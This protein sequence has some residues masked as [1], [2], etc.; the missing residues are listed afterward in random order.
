MRGDAA[1]GGDMRRLGENDPR[2][3]GRAGAE[4][5]H[6]P[7]VPQAVIGAVLAHRV[8]TMRLRAVTERKLIGWN[9][10]GVDM[11][12]GYPDWTMRCREPIASRTCEHS[13]VMG[14]AEHSV[15][16]VLGRPTAMSATPARCSRCS[17]WAPRCGRSTPC[18]SPTTPATG[19][20]PARSTPAQS[21]RDLVDGIA[22]RDASPA[23]AMRCCPAMWA[24]R[25]SATPSCTR[26]TASGGP[27]RRP[28]IAAIRSSATP[29]RGVYVRPGIEDFLRDRALPAADIVTPNRFEL[30]R[31]T[32]LDCGTLHGAKQAVLR[33]RPLLR[34]GRPGLRAADQPGDGRD[35]GRI[36]RHDD[37]S[38]RGAFI[39]C[40]RRCCRS[41]STA[42]AMRSRRC[43]CSTG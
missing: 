11:R 8:T 9:S 15:D 33:L 30:E 43:S 23:T 6:V 28:C 22:A 4:V 13:P 27:T 21:V 41:R 32:G 26:S 19:I 24:A 31:L 2:P 37:R 38:R 25:I 18:S 42:R 3:A 5:L 10:R 36:H 1:D 39:C 35:P 7:V 40:G 34:D 14:S 12:T 20:G 29:I 16:P 17:A